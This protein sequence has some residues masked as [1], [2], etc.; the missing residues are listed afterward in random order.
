MKDSPAPHPPTRRAVAG[1][2]STLRVDLVLLSV[3]LVWGMNFSVMKGLYEHMHPLAFTELRFVVGVATLGLILRLRG[4]S[5]HVDRADLPALIGFGFL[6][7]TVYQIIFVVGLARTRAGNAGLILAATPVFAYIAGLVTKR[8]RYK[9]GVLAG[10]LLS[11]AG[12]GG[13]VIFS[14]RGVALGS[15]WDGDL[16]MLASAVCWGWYTGSIGR[17]AAKY[18]AL[19]LTFWIMLTGTAFLIPMLAPWALRQNWGAVPLSGWLAAAYSTFLSICYS[20]LAWSYAIERVGVS[21]TAVYSCVT[22]IVALAGGWALL[23]ETPTAAQMIGVT[24]ILSGVVLVR[25]QAQYR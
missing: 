20:Y 11:V 23:G 5:L 17:L 18:G 12:V 19:R 1:A 8:E 16:L 7:N 9:S 14:S 10:I 24:M 3:T 15:S 21:R 13:V 25:Q 4:L 2:G 22:P 6:S